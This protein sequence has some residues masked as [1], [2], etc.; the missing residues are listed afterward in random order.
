M[1]SYEM[2]SPSSSR[3]RASP[4]S[5]GASSA[6]PHGVVS[7]TTLNNHHSRDELSPAPQCGSSGFGCSSHTGYAGTYYLIQLEYTRRILLTNY[8]TLCTM[9]NFQP[10][11]CIKRQQSNRLCTAKSSC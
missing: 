8:Y 3:R 10:Q 6:T 5:S 11:F 2:D 9:R 7:S 1:H 4:T